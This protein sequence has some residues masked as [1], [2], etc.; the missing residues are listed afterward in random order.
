MREG[1]FYSR[2]D[3]NPFKN[4][5]KVYQPY[6][7]S[8]IHQGIDSQQI[9]SSDPIVLSDNFYQVYRQIHWLL[10]N[11][12]KGNNGPSEATGGF[13]FDGVNSIMETLDLLDQKFDLS[14]TKSFVL[15]GNGT[16]KV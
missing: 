1:G 13:Y 11:Q 2:D 9:V 5:V 16:I 10:Y 6:C 3:E 7:T 14:K 8:D 15:K 4:F 12:Y